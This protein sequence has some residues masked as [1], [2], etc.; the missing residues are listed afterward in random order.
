MELPV[1]ICVVTLVVFVFGFA[2][3][4]CIA[5]PSAHRGT[6]RAYGVVVAESSPAMAD[7]IVQRVVV[8]ESSPA[9]A[10]GIVQRSGTWRDSGTCCG[11]I[12][13]RSPYGRR[14]PDLIGICGSGTHYHFDEK[15]P[16]FRAVALKD[17]IPNLPKHVDNSS[18]QFKTNNT[19]HASESRDENKLDQ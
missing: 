9:M 3:G 14:V 18:Q 2:C 8:A 7:V 19:P 4:W 1:V 13:Q 15:C 5:R 6:A 17:S 16:S 10:D 12:V 11:G